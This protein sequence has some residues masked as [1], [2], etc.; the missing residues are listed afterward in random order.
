MFKT[1]LKKTKAQIANIVNQEA[2]VEAVHEEFDGAADRMLEEA[3][4]LIKKAD[5]IS[6]RAEDLRSIGFTSQ[7]EVVNAVKMRKDKENSEFMLKL[8]LEYIEKFPDHKFISRNEINN[9]CKKYGL[10]FGDVDRFIG[11][12]P[13][14]NLQEIKNF[15][16][17]VKIPESH[18]KY[19]ELFSPFKSNEIFD[20]YMRSEE[21]RES[22]KR[23][24][25]T[26]IFE[27]KTLKIA[28]PKDQMKVNF[29]ER[30]DENGMIVRI[31]TDPVVFYPVKGGYLIISKWGKEADYEEFKD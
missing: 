5:G 22:I 3:K 24:V 20:E 29:G 4:I 18:K 19:I 21:Y 27:D 15:I 14:K 17:N 10:V 13:T 2:L 11:D 16:D 9:I 1:M 31:K 26:G 30:I 8:V 25:F 12:I 6:N 23:F 7:P 28:A